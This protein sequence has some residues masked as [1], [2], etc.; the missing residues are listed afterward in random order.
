M[1][2]ESASFIY[3]FTGIGLGA[4]SGTSLALPQLVGLARATEMA[5][6]NRPIS[7]EEALS[8]GLVNQVVPDDELPEVAGELA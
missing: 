5:F 6:T 7:A 8:W 3:G 2:A 1:A 4:D